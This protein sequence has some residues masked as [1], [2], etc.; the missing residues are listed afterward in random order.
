MACPLY[1][2]TVTDQNNHVDASEPRDQQAESL[3]ESAG[4]PGA[5]RF[6]DEPQT[7]DDLLAF[8]QAFRR[9][10]A[11]VA[12]VTALTPDGTPVGFTATS[13]ASLAA[14][15][16]MASF[17][18][19]RSA[20]A[21]PAIASTDYVIIHMLG[22]RNRPVAEIM[23]GDNGQRFAGDHWYAGPHGLPVLKDVTAWMLG[24]I[25]GRLPLHNNV[26]V[27][28]QIEDGGLGDDD[29][30]LLYHERSYRLLGDDA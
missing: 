6:P 25:V 12:V 28:V 18:M 4:E 9:H 10:A 2:G 29:E 23:S 5:V 19:A 3:I 17:N 16:P 11:G 30:A 7:P 13:L 24:R 21:W 26:M 20:S 15:P 14:V 22:A 27:A 8:K 1:E